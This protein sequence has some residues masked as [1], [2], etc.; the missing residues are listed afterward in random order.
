MLYLNKILIH[1][2]YL[3]K[4]L[5]IIISCF[6][7][8]QIHVL[9][10]ESIT[11][12]NKETVDQFSVF[13]WAKRGGGRSTADCVSKLCLTCTYCY[14]GN[15]MFGWRGNYAGRLVARRY[16]GRMVYVPSLLQLSNLS[17]SSARL[18]SAC[19]NQVDIY[20][21]LNATIHAYTYVY[22]HINPTHPHGATFTFVSF[23]NRY[24]CWNIK[25]H[26]PWF[27]IGNSFCLYFYFY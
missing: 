8:A 23:F 19:I 18:L 11:F 21:N 5:I 16:Y 24:F 25:L 17:V 9:R 6:A 13:W 15:P 2:L 3:N 22:L 26:S 14:H 12:D 27:H 1:M 20:L 4:I 10:P 7:L